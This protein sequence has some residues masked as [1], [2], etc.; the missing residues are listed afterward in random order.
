M[1]RI[2]PALESMIE[3]LAP[4]CHGILRFLET[5]FKL[6]PR[7]IQYL[8]ASAPVAVYSEEGSQLFAHLYFF[9]CNEH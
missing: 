7:I 8:D 9:I 3:A 6:D 4:N 1:N 2:I 5:L